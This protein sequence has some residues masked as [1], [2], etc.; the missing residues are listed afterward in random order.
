MQCQCLLQVNHIKFL[1]W[2][3]YLIKPAKSNL[4]LSLSLITRDLGSARGQIITKTSPIYY[5]A[6]IN[7][8]SWWYY[9]FV[10]HLSRQCIHPRI[11]QL[12]VIGFSESSAN[13][14]T[15]DI[16][17]RWLAEFMD[18]TFKLPSIKE[19]EKDIADWEKCLKIYSGRFYKRGCIAILHNC[20]NDQ[21]C[22]DMG[23]NPRRKKGFFADLFLPYGP[24]DYASPWR[25]AKLNL[26]ISP[27]YPIKVELLLSI[28]SNAIQH[29]HLVVLIN[30]VILK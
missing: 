17:S 13:L 12:A 24:L 25:L 28:K 18:G 5:V 27:Y 22:K 6:L 8:E 16:R 19:M 9:A 4:T 20:Y 7:I 3:G 10:L 14:Y 23:W 21:L 2:F 29:F 11:P 15:S 30:P 1:D 26:P